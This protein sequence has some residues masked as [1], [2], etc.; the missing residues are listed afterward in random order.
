M[1]NLGNTARTCRLSKKKQTTNNQTEK[2]TRGTKHPSNESFQLQCSVMQFQGG[3]GGRKK[4]DKYYKCSFSVLCTWPAL[5][6]VMTGQHV[7][8]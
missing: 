6:G 8:R 4:S 1:S 2:S 3:G 7:M 5:E